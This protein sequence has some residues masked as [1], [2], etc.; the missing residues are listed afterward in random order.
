[1]GIWNQYSFI[2]SDR[3]VEDGT[4]SDSDGFKYDCV[5]VIFRQRPGVGPSR[6]TKGFLLKYSQVP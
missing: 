1:M 2:T 6:T 3:T 5:W 4:F